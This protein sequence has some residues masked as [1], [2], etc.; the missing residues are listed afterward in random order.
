MKSQS[1]AGA[2]VKTVFWGVISLILYLLVFLNQEM[3]TGYFTR[4]GFYAVPVI[5]TAL[6]FSFIHGAFAN[7]FIDAIGFKPVGKGGH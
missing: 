2:A 5:V 3:V 4:G 1:Q 6:V 7:Y